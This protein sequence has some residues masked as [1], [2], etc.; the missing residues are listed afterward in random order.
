MDTAKIV[1]IV[2]LVVAIAAAFVEIPQIGLIFVVVGIAM[3]FLAVETD[4]RLLF[5][6]IAV[7]LAQVSGAFGTIPAVG[8]Y[9][10]NIMGNVS[11]IVNAGALTVILMHVKDRMTE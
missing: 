3:G 10:S 9:I 5:L 4:K 2:A 11:A 8:E 6:V 7:A 1:R